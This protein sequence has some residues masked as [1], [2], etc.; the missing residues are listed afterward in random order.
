MERIPVLAGPTGSGKTLLALRLGEEMPVE[1]V[2]ADATMVYR[3]LDVGTDK[4]SPEERRRV[5]HH[6]VDVLE[7]SEAMSVARWVAMAEAAI[8]EVLSRG[9][10]PLVVG[11]TGYYIRALSEGLPG[12]PPPDPEVQAALWQELEAK[13]LEPLQAELARA[14]LED[15]LRVGKNPR[16][17][18]RALE[19][20]RRTG[21]PLPVFPAAPPA[22][23]T[24]SWCFGPSGPGFSPSW[25]PGPGGS[26][27]RAW[28]RR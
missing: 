9:R 27:P 22:L 3:G 6:L 4:P 13:G 2:S 19:V 10:L 25:R 12:L 20:L 28:W 18:V 7:P 15:A 14:S 24:P 17:L 8:A 23:A 16:R 5:P 1:V 11:G 21:T 26:L